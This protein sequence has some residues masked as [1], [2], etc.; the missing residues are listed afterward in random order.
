[1]MLLALA[2][3]SEADLRVGN[4]VSTVSFSQTQ[5]V[6]GQASISS[7]LPQWRLILTSL[8]PSQ[9]EP[10]HLVIPFPP[11]HIAFYLRYYT[12][13]SYAYLPWIWFPRFCSSR[14][15]PIW[16]RKHSHI[17]KVESAQ[18]V[19]VAPDTIQCSQIFWKEI[20]LCLPRTS[21]LISP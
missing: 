13:R 14:I 12:K 6:L 20:Q 15:H 11:S 16:R 3:T 7:Y 21:S 19:N 18:K 1:M 5:H 10:F 17:N 2:L 8:L 4:W 9:P